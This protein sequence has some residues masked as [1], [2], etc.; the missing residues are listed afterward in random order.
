[1]GK[2]TCPGHTLQIFVHSSVVDAVAYGALPLGRRASGGTPISDWLGQQCPLDGQARVL[3]HPDIFVRS[4]N[5]LAR[6]MTYSAAGSYKQDQRL[7]LLDQL[8]SLI[9]P[10]L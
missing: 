2:A 5:R 10:F 3:V 9:A 6:V 7:R 1:M 4:L 8:D